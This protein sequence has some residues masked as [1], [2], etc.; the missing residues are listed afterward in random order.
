M[1]W[2]LLNG[3]LINEL[4]LTRDNHRPVTLTSDDEENGAFP[5]EYVLIECVAGSNINWL[6]F[7]ESKK[8]L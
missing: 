1:E 8:F 7:K 3:T 4:L 6:P 2:S 5:F